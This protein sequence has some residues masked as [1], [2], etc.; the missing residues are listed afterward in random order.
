MIMSD[1]CFKRECATNVH[2]KDSFPIPQKL[3]IINLTHLEKFL[4]L[5]AASIEQ[6]NELNLHL[7]KASFILE[8]LERISQQ[9]GLMS[10]LQKL[11]INLFECKIFEEDIYN[12]VMNIISRC[13]TLQD[14]TLD[15][16]LQN[17]SKHSF[18]QLV[19]FIDS[20]FTK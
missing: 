12:L 9:I 16:I 2:L 7:P 8:F 18:I 11:N 13:Q 20:S 19:Q 15:F 1:I 14:I 17:Y 6:V 5:E 3:E 4:D 10:S